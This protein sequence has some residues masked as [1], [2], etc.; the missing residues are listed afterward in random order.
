MSVE[1]KEDLK[2]L[3]GGFAT[4]SL[5]LVEKWAPFYSK[6]RVELGLPPEVNEPSYYARLAATMCE[7][8][9]HYF[10][11]R[12]RN[13]LEPEH[14]PTAEF[15]DGFFRALVKVVLQSA[16]TNIFSWQPMQQAVGGV[17]FLKVASD[18]DDVVTAAG[19]LD[20]TPEFKLE[21]KVEPVD[22]DTMS[23]EVAARVQIAEVASKITG[24]VVVMNALDDVITLHGK[25][26]IALHGKGVWQD[27]LFCAV[28]ELYA[29]FERQAV[30]LAME[31]EDDVERVDIGTEAEGLLGLVS[32][33]YQIHRLSLRGP[34]NVLVMGPELFVQIKDWKSFSKRRVNVEPV[35]APHRL[36]HVGVVDGRFHVYMDPMLMGRRMLMARAGAS[37]IDTGLVVA[38][39]V[40]SEDG[41]KFRLRG[42]LKE[43]NPS[44]FL[45]LEC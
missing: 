19:L 21:L 31:T 42:A 10:A 11:S 1:T 34:A 7:T 12:T 6:V 33:S 45:V 20:A 5:A 22:I 13:L 29:D 26:V 9:A 8:Q 18:T 38:P 27:V 3:W 17:A 41:G 25:D 39:F 44:F 4:A 24:G 23:D 30:R 14:E 32:R 2:A 16:T 40:I 28:E 37:L 43:V 15:V 36:H 35:V